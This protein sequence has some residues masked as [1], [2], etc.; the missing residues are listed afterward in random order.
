MAHVKTV[1]NTVKSYSKLYIICLISFALL[2]VLSFVFLL[3]G[4]LGERKSLL[5]FAGIWWAGWGSILGLAALPI[6]I[7]IEI[8]TGGVKGGVHRYVR[9]VLSIFL[10]TG[11]CIS[12]FSMSIP[13][14]K[15]TS[16][17]LFPLIFMVII[18]IKWLVCCL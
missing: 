7:T 11:A 16:Q 2:S 12:L 18:L 15:V 14:E 10:L 3:L 1:G 5:V 4:I 17:T 8:I 13:N 6:G 9:W